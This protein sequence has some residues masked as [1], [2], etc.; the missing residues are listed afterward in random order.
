MYN[1]TI[2]RF[3]YNH[4][5]NGNTQRVTYSECVFV[6]LGSSMQCACA[7]LSSVAFPVLQYFSTLSHKRHDFQKKV[8]GH[9]MCVLIVSTTISEIFL[10]LR[11]TE[12]YDKIKNVCWS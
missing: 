3:S 5:F 12:R 4:F 9:R 2:I 7:I 8:I 10:I 11:K 6:A 1:V